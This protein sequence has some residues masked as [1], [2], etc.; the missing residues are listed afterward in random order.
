MNVINLYMIKILTALSVI[1]EYNF[2]ILVN[3]EMRHK[4][5]A[6]NC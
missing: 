5:F 2:I 1:A 6:E 3:N 4:W